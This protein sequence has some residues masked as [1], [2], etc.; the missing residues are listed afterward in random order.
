MSSARNAPIMPDSSM[1]MAATKPRFRSR[2]KPVACGDSRV[3]RTI[4]VD[5]SISHSEIPSTPK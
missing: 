5:K 4:K 2:T 1:S 3:T